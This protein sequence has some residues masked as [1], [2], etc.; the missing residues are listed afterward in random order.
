MLVKNW[1]STDVVTAS[2]DTRLHDAADLLKT[3]RIRRLCVVKGDKLVGIVTDSD[4]K[5]A[6]PSDATTL[7]IHELAYLLTQVK[8]KEILTK[9][10]IT[11]AADKTIDDAAVIMLKY[12]ISSLP[13]MEGSRLVGIIT[14]SDIFKALVTLSGVYQGGIQ[15]GFELVDRPG[16][17]KEVADVIRSYEGRMVSI[18]TSYENARQGFRN[19]YIRVKG[20]GNKKLHQLK[21]ALAPKFRILY[22]HESCKERVRGDASSTRS[23]RRMT[24]YWERSRSSESLKGGRVNG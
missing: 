15:F 21:E 16:S 24:R 14:E 12:R 13:V 4:I 3:Y 23:V 6:S 20:L 1:M 11:I 19:V 8:L 18:L 22:V 5:E 10:P 2:P 7:S 17:I 9:D